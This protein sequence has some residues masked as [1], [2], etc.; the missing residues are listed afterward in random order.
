MTN[1]KAIFGLRGAGF[2]VLNG[3]VTEG[4][5]AGTQIHRRSNLVGIE[6]TT[7][8]WTGELQLIPASS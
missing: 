3:T 2:L 8:A 5:F 4:S 1:I 6:G 7:S